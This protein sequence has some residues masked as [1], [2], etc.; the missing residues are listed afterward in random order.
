MDP[1][2]SHDQAPSG[3]SPSRTERLKAQQAKLSSRVRETQQRLES[4]RPRSKS[5]DAV[6]RTMERD[7]AAGGGVLAGAVAFRIFLFLVPFVF[8][9]VVGFGLGASAANESPRALAESAGVGGL[10]AKAFASVGDLSVGERVLSLLVAGLALFLATRA[11]VKVLRIVHALVWHVRAD[12]LDRPMRWVLGTLALVSVALVLT[13][14]LATL[15]GQSFVLGLIATLL[16]I[17]IPGGLWLLVSWHLPHRDVPWTALVPGA[18]FLGVG[19]QVLNLVTV[20]WIA[21]QI[22]SKTDTYGAIGFA[23]ALLL[24]AYILGRLITTAAVV[25]ESLWA[26]NEERL[27][28]RHERES[29]R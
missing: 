19:L 21:H 4:A 13:T 11:L 20:Y 28:A 25:N 18:V 14:L 10:A 27:R 3:A 26:R 17:V 5:V 22:E 23:L 16:W 15:R 8:V 12:K 1:P 6:F 24:W 2:E 9:L 7:T 29:P